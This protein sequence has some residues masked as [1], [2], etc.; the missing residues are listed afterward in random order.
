MTVFRN[1]DQAA[2]DAQYNNMARVPTGPEH[3]ARWIETSKAALARPGWQCDIAYGDDEGERLDVFP[4]KGPKAPIMMFF[5]G[6]YWRSRD[7]SEFAFLLEGFREA[8]A[9]FV[10][11]NYALCPKVSMSE[12]MRQC[13]KAL[14]WTYRHA[15]DFGA[16]RDRLFISGHSAGGH[17]VGELFSTDWVG[18]EAGLPRDPIKGG[19]A[20]SGL[21]DLAPIRLCFLNA[22][23]RMDAAEAEALSPV[24]NVPPRGPKL[25]LAVGG[26]ESEEY[27]R[28]QADYAAA[29]RAKRLSVSEVAMPGHDHFSIIGA[30]ADAKSP[31]GRAAL[32]LMG[33][34][35]GRRS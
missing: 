6:G 26:I 7:K 23:L 25:V 19:L 35:Q 32:A 27:H 20:I 15:G 21:Y 34:V 11:V 8:G 9:A 30:L 13:R 28:Q 22:D 31:L 4:G 33:L 1:Y 12:L 16:D 29:L 3:V 24:K 5:H 14:A 17:I 10:N 2:L 18:F